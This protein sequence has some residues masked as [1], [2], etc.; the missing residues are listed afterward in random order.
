MERITIVRPYTEEEI[1]VVVTDFE[2]FMEELGSL[3]V[4]TVHDMY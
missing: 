1:T 3:K 4:G 2:A